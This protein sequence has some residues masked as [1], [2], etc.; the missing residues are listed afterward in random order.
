MITDA[1][2]LCKSTAA[3]TII[4]INPSLNVLQT[5]NVG[6]KNLPYGT[7]GVGKTK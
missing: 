3:A 1:I 2:S 5:L 7:T 4:T 6:L